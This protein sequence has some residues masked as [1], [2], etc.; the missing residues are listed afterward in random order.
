M[1]RKPTLTLVAQAEGYFHE[2]V[3]SSLG[4]QRVTTKPETEFYLV[5]LLSR[6]ISTESL[7]QRDG[8]GTLREEP[9]ISAELRRD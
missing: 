6:F 1:D 2:L 9:L 8:N 4:R 3:T 5:N 7:Y